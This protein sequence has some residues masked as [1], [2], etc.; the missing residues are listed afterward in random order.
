[1]LFDH[2]AHYCQRPRKPAQHP[3][4]DGGALKNESLHLEPGQI[5]SEATC[6]MVHHVLCRFG[7]RGELPPILRKKWRWSGPQFHLD[8]G[9]WASVMS[10]SISLA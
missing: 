1:M 7:R 5:V 10:G 9:S 4:F 6:P 3:K 8:C 2:N